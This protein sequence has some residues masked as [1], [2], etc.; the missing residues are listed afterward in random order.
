MCH[1]RIFQHISQLL[2]FSL[3]GRILISCLFRSCAINVIVVVVLVSIKTSYS[4]L[5]SKYI[6]RREKEKSVIS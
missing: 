6:K 2:Y 3:D 5:T 1:I 4:C